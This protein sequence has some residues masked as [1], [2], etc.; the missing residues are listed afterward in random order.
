VTTPPYPVR[1]G[2]KLPSEYTVSPRPERLYLDPRCFLPNPRPP[3]ESPYPRLGLEVAAQWSVEMTE[4]TFVRTAFQR[5]SWF[6]FARG[7]GAPRT[8]HR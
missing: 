7:G 4:S 1:A 5:S 2:V 8:L 3:D 6:S